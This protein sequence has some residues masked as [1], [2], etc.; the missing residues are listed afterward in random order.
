MRILVLLSPISATNPHFWCAPECDTGH[1]HGKNK[2]I[3]LTPR[4]HAFGG[5]TPAT[6][7]PVRVKAMQWTVPPARVL[8]L[9]DL[10]NASGSRSFVSSTP[11]CWALVLQGLTTMNLAFPLHLEF[12]PCDGHM[13]SGCMNPFKTR[14]WRAKGR[15]LPPTEIEGCRRC[16]RRILATN[17][18]GRY[19][20]LTLEFLDAPA[21]LKKR[22][23]L[24]LY[25]SPQRREP[26]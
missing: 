26:P 18:V 24:K 14:V 15:C 7:Y 22:L 21:D 1:C 19:H 6:A 9:H 11:E 20:K 17:S 13:S 23:D 16:R 8:S 25:S 12:H 3:V 5:A 4:I 2:T 10:A